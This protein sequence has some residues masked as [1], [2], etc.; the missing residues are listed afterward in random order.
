MNVPRVKCHITD[1]TN[2]AKLYEYLIPYQERLASS[3]FNSSTTINDTREADALFELLKHFMQLAGVTGKISY[4][5]CCHTAG[6]ASG[7]RCTESQ[8]YY[9]NSTV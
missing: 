8:Y 5:L 4:H 2:I 7:G 6:E 3:Y 1:R 9:K